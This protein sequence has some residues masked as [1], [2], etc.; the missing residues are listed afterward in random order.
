[1]ASHEDST[2]TG[3]GIPNSAIAPVLEP[4]IDVFGDHSSTLEGGA[5]NAYDEKWDTKLDE[6][7]EKSPLTLGEGEDGV[8]RGIA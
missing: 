2:E 6:R 3:C 1:V 5:A 4:Q 8:V 7:C